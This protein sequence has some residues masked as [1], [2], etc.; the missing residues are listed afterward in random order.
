MREIG[1]IV[2]EHIETQH[3]KSTAET[4]DVLAKQLRPLLT[5]LDKLEQR[6]SALAKQVAALET[7]A[8]K[9]LS[10]NAARSSPKN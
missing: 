5:R 6:Q 9:W 7:K 1:Q 10:L 2:R 4:A 8:E 3:Q